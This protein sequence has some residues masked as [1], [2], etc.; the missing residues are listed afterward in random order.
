MIVKFA[1]GTEVIDGRRVRSPHEK[2]VFSTWARVTGQDAQQLLAHL[3][4]GAHV[5]VDANSA[6]GL[7]RGWAMAS[8]TL[9]E[10]F[11]FVCRPFLGTEIGEHIRAQLLEALAGEKA[12]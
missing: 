10:P 5:F 7:V 6:D 4:R 2:F 11:L 9:R 12:A 1:P 8:P 3:F